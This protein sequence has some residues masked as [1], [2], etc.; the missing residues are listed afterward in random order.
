MCKFI[1][2]RRLHY[3][4]ARSAIHH[5]AVKVSPGKD[6]E[7]CPV[8]FHIKQ[9]EVWKSQVVVI[10]GLDGI[11]GPVTYIRRCMGFQECYEIRDVCVIGCD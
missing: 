5:G 10:I 7:I 4:N 8:K 3:V 6:C 9:G 11:A 2:N 1:I